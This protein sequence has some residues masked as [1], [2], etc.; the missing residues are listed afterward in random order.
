MVWGPHGTKR[1]LHRDRLPGEEGQQMIDDA[2]GVG[3]R[4]VLLLGIPAATADG[5]DL[6]HPFGVIGDYDDEPALI[7]RFDADRAR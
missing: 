4:P 7:P 3:N 5:F 6:R 2:I 1:R